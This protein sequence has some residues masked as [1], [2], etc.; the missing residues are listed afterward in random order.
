LIQCTKNVLDSVKKAS[1]VV[2]ARFD[3]KEFGEA[4]LRALESDIEKTDSFMNGLMNYLKISM[5]VRKANTVRTLIEEVLSKHQAVLERYRTRLVTKFEND[6]PETAVPDEQLRYILDS[7]VQLAVDSIGFHGTLGVLTR[8]SPRREK[9][10]G[11]LSGGR[12]GKVEIFLL[13]SDCR[14]PPQPSGSV[15]GIPGSR[16]EEPR[17]LAFLLAKDMVLRNR[18]RIK[19]EMDEKSS[20]TMIALSIPVERRTTVYYS[21]PEGQEV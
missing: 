14:K 19:F 15:V 8:S 2:Q 9:N 6:L 18:G 7:L 1:H 11:D 4:L 21:P 12:N 16:D 20:R 5:P 17:D 10:E 13:Y 3:D